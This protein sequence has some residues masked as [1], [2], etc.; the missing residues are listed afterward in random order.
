MLSALEQSQ[1]F[2]CVEFRLVPSHSGHIRF[3][4]IIAT[5]N[6]SNAGVILLLKIS[7]SISILL[8]LHLPIAWLMDLK[9]Y[10]RLFFGLPGLCIYA[11]GLV[12]A[13]QVL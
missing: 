7:S 5:L 13:L 6:L 1:H 4:L 8:I 3:A 10:K 12:P 9:V 2:V 11:S